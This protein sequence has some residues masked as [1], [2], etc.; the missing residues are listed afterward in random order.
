M[1]DVCLDCGGWKPEITLEAMG[2]EHDV[3]RECNCC[4][5]QRASAVMVKVLGE[6]VPINTSDELDQFRTAMIDWLCKNDRHG[7]YT[8]EASVREGFSPMTVE[9]AMWFIEELEEGAI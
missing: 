8:D 5:R 7:I 9:E 2:D 6:E 4:I 1:N 3:R